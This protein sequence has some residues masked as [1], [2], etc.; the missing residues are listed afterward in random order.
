MTQVT[1]VVYT[2]RKI[3]LPEMDDKKK[4]EDDLKK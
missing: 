1:E 2:D 4:K 3:A